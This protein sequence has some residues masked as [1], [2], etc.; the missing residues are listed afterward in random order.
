M[1]NRL[2]LL[3]GIAL[4]LLAFAGIQSG[5]SA[6][7]QDQNPNQSPN[8]TQR[9][10]MGRGMGPGG[11]PGA[12]LGPLGFLAGRLNLTDDQKNQIKTIAQS[13]QAELQ[14]LMQAARTAHQAL[15]NALFNSPL[16]ENLIR[17]LSAQV[18]A[19]DVELELARGRLLSDVLQVL[20]PDQLATLKTLQSQMAQRGPRG[21]GKGNR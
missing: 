6:S 21:F 2:R 5:A 13:H 15:E 12:V 8:A 20:T 4:L 10:F 18:A 14:P 1:A 16:D 17:Q 7:A 19:A 9:P 3:S 11:G